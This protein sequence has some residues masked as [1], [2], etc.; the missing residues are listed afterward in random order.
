FAL[1]EKQ[2]KLVESRQQ[3]TRPEGLVLGLLIELLQTCL[4][5]SLQRSE[6]VRQHAFKGRSG[7]RCAR[8]GPTRAIR[9]G[10]PRIEAAQNPRQLDLIK[11]VIREP[12][13][14]N[15]QRLEL[16]GDLGRL[17]QLYRSRRSSPPVARRSVLGTGLRL[18]G[19]TLGRSLR[20]LLWRDHHFG[21]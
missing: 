5:P 17:G 10:T 18:V 3:A 12:G 15:K 2:P 1:R 9:I 20:R 21:Q 8:D 16:L 11:V 14:S 7:S 6:R 4:A 13:T 19:R